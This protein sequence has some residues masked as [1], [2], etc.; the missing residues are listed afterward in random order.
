MPRTLKI[1]YFALVF[2]RLSRFGHGAQGTLPV[3]LQCDGQMALCHGA[4]LAATAANWLFAGS[5]Q[6]G[7]RAAAVMSLIQSARLN[8]YDP[9]ACLK[10]GATRF[11]F[12][13]ELLFR[14][15]CLSCFTD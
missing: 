4:L 11:D 6:A 14:L 12:M 10:D 7:Q 8:G 13:A 2:V 9:Y 1:E 15:F 5:L 3:R